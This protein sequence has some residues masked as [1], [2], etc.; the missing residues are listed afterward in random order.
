MPSLFEMVTCWL[1]HL[2]PAVCQ[3]KWFS[4]SP[5]I[6]SGPELWNENQSWKVVLSG[7][8][9]CCLFLSL[10]APRAEII[11]WH[12]T[13]GL[14][15]KLQSA[16]TP[17]HGIWVDRWR[18]REEDRVQFHFLLSLAEVSYQMFSFFYASVVTQ[19][20]FCIMFVFVFFNRV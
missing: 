9:L 4:L 17:T 2:L 15:V 14:M 12:E 10:W 11:W 3:G 1:A 16:A 5:L 19:W 7:K 18:Y 20:M 8:K 13:A 6:H